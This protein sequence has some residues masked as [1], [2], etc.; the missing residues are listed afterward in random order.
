MLVLLLWMRIEL[1]K[2]KV[3][4][5]NNAQ[6]ARFSFNRG[7]SIPFQGATSMHFVL[8]GPKIVLV[9]KKYSNPVLETVKFPAFWLTY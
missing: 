5:S 4:F 3:G 1:T 2:P 9:I 6:K 7:H 8:P